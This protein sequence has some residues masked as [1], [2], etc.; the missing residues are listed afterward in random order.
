[1]NNIFFFKLVKRAGRH[2]GFLQRAGR[3][4]KGAGR[5]ALQK[6]P[7]QNTV[8]GSS[9]KG[10]YANGLYSHKILNHAII[11]TMTCTRISVCGENITWEIVQVLNMLLQK[12][13]EHTIFCD[14]K[15]N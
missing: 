7:R 14:Y 8:I 5:R 15:L 1:M 10:Q 13:Y 3:H 2:F 9:L 4:Q 6:R 12:R 11:I